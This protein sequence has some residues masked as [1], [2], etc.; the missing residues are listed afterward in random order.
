MQ[1]YQEVLDSKSLAW[2]RM[3][4]APLGMFIILGVAG[5]RT[6]EG[7]FA[8]STSLAW[9]I[10]GFTATYLFATWFIRY[11]RPH[12]PRRVLGDGLIVGYAVLCMALLAWDPSLLEA[13]IFGSTAKWYMLIGAALS[14]L[15][16]PT[17]IFLRWMVR[18]AVRGF[19]EERRREAELPSVGISQVMAPGR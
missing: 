6:G 5:L 7:V 8:G 13:E 11:L 3:A 4:V 12:K 14:F 1:W 15:A 16:Y 19:K 2:L 17:A 18:R 9:A 10:A